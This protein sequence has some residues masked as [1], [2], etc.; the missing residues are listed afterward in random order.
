MSSDR[1]RHRT[2]GARFAQNLLETLGWQYDASTFAIG[3]Q[4]PI[5]RSEVEAYTRSSFKSEDEWVGFR[6][7]LGF[8][9]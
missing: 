3:C 8:P 2:E 1:I 7:W 9:L 4:D 6:H 5:M